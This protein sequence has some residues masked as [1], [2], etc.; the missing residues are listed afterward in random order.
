M[1]ARVASIT[2]KPAELEHHPVDR[3]SRIAVERV[4]LVAGHGILG[5]TK[6]RSDSRQLNV[7]LAETVEQLRAEG[8]RCAPGELGEQFVIAGLSTENASP[9]TRLRLGE[10]AIIELVYLRIPCGRFA[11]I[12]D[13]P[14]DAGRGRLGFMARVL[15]GGEV[16][17]D[18]AVTVEPSLPASSNK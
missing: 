4:M 18:S 13:K 3:F 8:F 1:T 10:S 9:G 14:K 7:M 15:V 5:D 11:R 16:M 12:Q 2:S 6:S 17:V